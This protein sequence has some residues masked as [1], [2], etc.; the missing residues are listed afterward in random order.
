MQSPSTIRQGNKTLALWVSSSHL[1]SLSAKS[2]VPDL[3]R[4]ETGS[5][6]RGVKE[7]RPPCRL[8]LPFDTDSV[9]YEIASLCCEAR[10]IPCTQINIMRAESGN[11][12]LNV[13]SFALLPAGGSKK[14]EARMQT[15][16]SGSSIQENQHRLGKGKQV[17]VP[18]NLGRKDF[19][20]KPGSRGAWP[21]RCVETLDLGGVSSSPMLGVELN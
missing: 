15:M 6:L 13:P 19:H 5:H 17:D 11:R 14:P 9:M 16:N 2:T 8:P 20:S 4:Y 3:Y 7:T 21:A 12:L 10:K 18:D 1:M